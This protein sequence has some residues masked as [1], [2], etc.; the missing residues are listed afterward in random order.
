[1]KYIRLDCRNRF[2]LLLAVLVV[3][4][5]CTRTP[6]VSYYQLSALDAGEKAAGENAIADTVIG[7]GPIRLPDR[8][9]RP[10]IV[11]MLNS[12]QVQVAETHRWVEPLIETIPRVLR[13][14]LSLLLHTERFQLYPWS[15]AA[16]V[17]YQL[18]VE[19]I[20]FEGEEYQAAHL[21]AIWSIQDREGK[22]LLPPQ[23]SSYQS[24]IS[25][26]DHA[27][28]VSALSRTLALFSRD[29][30]QQLVLLAGKFSRDKT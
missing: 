1:M 10:Q 18:S 25:T 14:N 6:Q 28:L 29:A 13:E 27:G 3:T 24:R 19:I 8:L 30:A 26:Q 4:A 5:G 11:T 2:L 12:N 7:I 9:D 15:R 21:E 17:D 16:G 20:R 22:I 23:R